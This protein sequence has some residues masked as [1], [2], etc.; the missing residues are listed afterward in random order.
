MPR[1]PIPTKGACEQDRLEGIKQLVRLGY[2]VRVVAKIFSWQNKKEIDDFAQQHQIVVQCVAY[3]SEVKE[4]SW[5]SLIRRLFNPFYWDGAAYEYASNSIRSAVERELS[6][7]RPDAVW[8]EYT[9]L[10]PLYSLVKKYNLPIITRSINFEPQHN[11]GEGEHSLAAV[12]GYIPKLLSEYRVVRNSDVLFAITPREQAIYKRLGGRTA[13]LPLRALPG[14]LSYNYEV[15]DR[16]I[17]NVFF[18]GSTYN[19]AHNKKALYYL[20]QDIIPGITR[21]APQSFK[22]YILGSKLPAEFEGLLNEQV[23]YA[24]FVP[25]LDA[26]LLDMDIALVPSMFGAGMQ[27]K[28]FEPLSR[29]LPTVTSARGLAGY[30]YEDKKHILLADKTGDFLD[31]LVALRDYNLRQNIS[32]EAH[33]LSRALFSQAALDE[34]I[35]SNLQYV[36]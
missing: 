35:N 15:K 17:L 12:A 18:M 16:A 20:L 3:E 2:Q 27:Q 25:D 22:F 30:P 34:I 26:F 7:W 33:K 19:V 6:V 21:L 29:G 23:V 14:F 5:R 8:F 36:K 10:W 1:F 24:G 13:L 28:I 9:Y 31:A 11:W 4:K 32:A